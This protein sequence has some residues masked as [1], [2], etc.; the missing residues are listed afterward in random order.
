METLEDSLSALSTSFKVDLNLAFVPSWRLISPNS[1]LA[2][3]MSARR[4]SLAIKVQAT[5]RC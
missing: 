3:K 4:C 5:A 2:W 1:S